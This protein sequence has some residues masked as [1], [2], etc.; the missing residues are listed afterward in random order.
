M[1]NVQTELGKLI[2]GEPERDAIHIAVAPIFAGRL[3]KAG[4]HVGLDNAGQA[5]LT[6]DPIGIVDPF[7]ERPVQRGQRFWLFLYPNTITSL[8]HVWTHPAFEVA[9]KSA[10]EQWLKDFLGSNGPDYDDL[11][12]AVNNGGK[13]T[14]TDQE[15]DDYYGVSI[16]GDYVHVNGSDAHGEIPSEFWDHVENV[17]GRKMKTRPSYFTCSC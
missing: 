4:D 7:L 8:K 16:E 5:N 1:S 14:R 11:I 3:L 9:A 17:T 13:F 15:Y 12:A 10:S 6:S 2:E